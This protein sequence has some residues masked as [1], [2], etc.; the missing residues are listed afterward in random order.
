MSSSDPGGQN[1]SAS[2]PVPQ[3][4]AFEQHESAG[5]ATPATLKLLVEELRVEKRLIE[6]DG[7]R[8]RVVTDEVETPVSVMLRTESLDV[9]RVPIDRFVD[10]VP[11]IREEDGVTIVPVVEEVVVTEVRLILKE[12]LHVRRIATAREHRDVV[13]LRRQHAEVERLPS[14]GKDL[15]RS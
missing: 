14:T 5:L 6:G 1:A 10:R 2:A 8:I 11:D 4:D 3:P 7:V 9:R 15:G 12:E 13:T